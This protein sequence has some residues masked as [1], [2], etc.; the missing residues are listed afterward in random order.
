MYVANSN[1]F[2]ATNCC[3]NMRLDIGQRSHLSFDEYFEIDSVSVIDTETRR[4]VS[5]CNNTH[6]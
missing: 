3:I 5:F 1:E 2:H 4:P 6:G